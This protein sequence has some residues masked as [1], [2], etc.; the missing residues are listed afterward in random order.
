MYIDNLT[1]AIL[2]ILKKKYFIGKTYEISDNCLISN[3]K[4]VRLIAKGL[5][6]KIKIFYLNPKIINLMLIIIGKSELFDKMLKEFIVSN[7]N[8]I[9]DTGWTPPYHY[10]EGI[11][12]TC[13]WYKRTFTINKSCSYEIYTMVK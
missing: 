6:K 1:D 4:L 2:F 8:F 12:K 7:K 3:E 9:A 11:K 10:S 5:G 13:L